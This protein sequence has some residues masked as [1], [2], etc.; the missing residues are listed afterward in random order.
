MILNWFV[1]GTVRQAN[2][3]RRHVQKHLNHQR[4]ILPPQAVE[5]VQSALDSLHAALHGKL[6]KPGLEKEVQNVE[7][8]AN[9]WLK[10][11]PHAAWRENIEVLVVALAIAMGVRTFFLQP[12]KIPTGSMQPTLYGVTSVNLMGTPPTTV[13]TGLQRVRDWFAGISYLHVIAKNDGELTSV[14]KPFRFLIFSIYQTLTIGGQ[15]YRLWFPPDYG[16]SSLEARAELRYR[17]FFHRGEDVIKVKV[18]AGDHL[19]VDRLTYNFR[20]PKRG[21][22]IVF[23]TK[24]IP[25]DRREPYGIPGDQF[26]IKRLVGLGGERLQLGPDRHLV[27][28]GKRLNAS[29]PHFER[30]YSFDPKSAPTDSQY[31]GHVNL[32]HLAA[33]FR[34]Y[35]DGVLVPEDHYVAMGDNTINSLDSRAWGTFP[36]QYVIGKSFFVYWPI[37]ERFGWGYHR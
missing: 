32:P 14:G 13:P 10:P 18:S 15:T 9:K 34:S 19:F 2:S 26:Y 33:Y 16:Q 35:P 5:A 6:D 28:N 17:Q 23:E 27:V 1:S 4:D 22:I 11:Y 21:E 24:G 7:V 31:S 36:S 3:I 12:F 8:A 29:M 37:T 30:V 20:R 25:A